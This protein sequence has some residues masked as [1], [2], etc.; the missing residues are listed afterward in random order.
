MPTWGSRASL[1]E[2]VESPG[3][4]GL[5]CRLHC[6]LAVEEMIIVV[7]FNMF[8]TKEAEGAALCSLGAGSVERGVAGVCGPP[9]MAEH[10][11]LPHLPVLGVRLEWPC[12]AGVEEPS[13]IS[14]A[15][16]MP[17]L[18]LAVQSWA[19]CARKSREIEILPQGLGERG[20]QDTHSYSW[21]EGTYTPKPLCSQSR[22]ASW[23]RWHLESRNFQQI[24]VE[25][26]H[27]KR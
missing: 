10:P 20:A 17:V 6:C 16:W 7:I 13:G 12:V 1:R 15:C 5:L 4:G 11:C 18:C 19:V 23:R 8:M 21:G 9:Q 24:E 14:G 22:E 27:S 3:K 26:G 25:E 2:D